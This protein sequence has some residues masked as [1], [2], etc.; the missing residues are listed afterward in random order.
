MK[1]NIIHFSMLEGINRKLEH[2][3]FFEGL[4]DRLK[5]AILYMDEI[6]FPE[7]LNTK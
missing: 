5:Y 6:F 7:L 2:K 4:T 1:F 3:I